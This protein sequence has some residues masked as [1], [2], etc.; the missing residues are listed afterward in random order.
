MEEMELLDRVD[1]GGI[2][3]ATDIID[4]LSVLERL[5]SRSAA[6]MYELV[7]DILAVRRR[8]RAAAGLPPSRW[9]AGVA[10]EVALAMSISPNRA[11]A[12]LSRAR[13]LHECLPHTLAR[14]WDGDI[15]PERV[16]ILIAG[17]AH[18]DADLRRRADA[19]LCA[20]PTVLAGLGTRRL[21]DTV[22][23]M[24]YQ[25]D[26]QAMVDRLAKAEAHRRVTIRPEP[27][28]MARVSI[29]LPV[30]KAVAVFASLKRRADGIVGVGPEVR[31]RGQVMADAA[32]ELLA[33]RTAADGQPV[34]V[35]ITVSDRVL[36]GGGTGTAHLAGGGAIPG[37]VARNLVARAASRGEAWLR[38]LYVQPESGAVVGMDSRSRAFP[39]GLG[40]LIAARDR[41]CRTPYCDAP[42]AHNDHV[43][44]HAAGG[45]TSIDNGQ[46][47]CAACNYAKQA[48][49]W[50]QRVVDDPS[51]RHTVET[52]TP[53]GAVHRS[54]APDAA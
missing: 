45:E 47:L 37:E 7:F 13:A 38:R 23:Q 18:L 24:A 44:P 8:E 50:E 54:T 28:A 32:F 14:L 19:L 35:N 53:T 26:R 41:T 6:E 27:D 10:A 49:G 52:I 16:E 21:Q 12:I 42:I 9:D 31:T 5:R 29:L 1:A 33:G 2:R 25:L 11:T 46:G 22:F 34:S 40:A 43:I 39:D 30:A 17:V 20:D 15:S 4:R 3:V 51:G 48:A 36:L